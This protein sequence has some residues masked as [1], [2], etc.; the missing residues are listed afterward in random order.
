MKIDRPS[1]EWKEKFLAEVGKHILRGDYRSALP[2]VAAARKKYPHDVFCRYQYAKILG[3]WADELPPARKKKLKREAIAILRPLLRALGGETPKTRFGIC[4]NYY[5]QSEDFPGMV[6][7]GRKLAARRD[8]R[9]YYAMGIGSSL[10]A[11]RRLKAKDGRA[12]AWARKSLAAW[13]RYGLSGE[14]YYFPHYIQAMAYAVLGERAAGMRS[15]R[16]AARASK[17]PVTDWEFADVLGLLVPK[18]TNP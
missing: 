10:E 17:R 1:P 11:L 3:D 15:L 6:R 14:K 5:Y 13:R 9:G 12:K 8:R 16:R 4:L 7:F 2:L 18:E